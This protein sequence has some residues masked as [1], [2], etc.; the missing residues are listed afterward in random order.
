MEKDLEEQKENER[1]IRDQS[2]TNSTVDN[3]VFLFSAS[4]KK[5]E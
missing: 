1:K 3:Q 2:E 4:P 5:E